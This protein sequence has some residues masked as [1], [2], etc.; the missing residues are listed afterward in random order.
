VFNPSQA[1]AE[2]K[3][4]VAPKKDVALSVPLMGFSVAE[5]DKLRHART[6]SMDQAPSAKRQAA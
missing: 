5:L 1:A 2:T 6:K 3:A 4:P